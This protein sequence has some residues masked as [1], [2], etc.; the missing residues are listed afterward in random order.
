MKQ[1]TNYTTSINTQGPVVEGQQKTDKLMLQLPKTRRRKKI[2]F[3][4]CVKTDLV[5]HIEK[6]IIV[7]IIYACLRTLFLCYSYKIQSFFC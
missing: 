4:K 1:M 5:S 7:N 3:H 2:L 6:Q